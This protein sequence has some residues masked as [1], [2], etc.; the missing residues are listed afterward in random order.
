MITPIVSSERQRVTQ[1]SRL[2]SLNLY[3]ELGDEV[4]FGVSCHLISLIYYWTGDIDKAFKNVFRSY[5]ILE[6]VDNHI[7]A[8]F[9]PLFDL[10]LYSFHKK[11]FG[12]LELK[13]LK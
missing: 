2:I 10:G 11:K 7:W 3:K 1:P 13:F 12:I 6:N 9:F 5:E 8:L 4:G